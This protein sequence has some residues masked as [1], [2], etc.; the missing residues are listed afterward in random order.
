MR[1]KNKLAIFD[2]DGTLTNSVRIHQLA[3]VNALEELGFAGFDT[4]WNNY[5]HHTDSYIFDAIFQHQYKKESTKRDVEQFESTL[6]NHISKEV[7]TT[8]IHEIKAAAY[9][10]QQLIQYSEFDI[11][12]A[13]GSLLKPAIQK[14][15]L[16]NISINDNLISAA[17]EIFSRE[18]LVLDAIGKAKNYY[19]KNSYEKIISFGDGLWDF[20]TANNLN[21]DFIGI[22]NSRLLEY[23]IAHFFSDFDNPELFR[24]LNIKIG[25]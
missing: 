25:S 16:A 9:F 18:E 3:F 22:G 1:I 6:N 4:N 13:T 19:C 12:F 7:C 8:P 5:K 24:L 23:G 20:T 17:N 11:V 10:L 21:I 15:S 2:I 14:L